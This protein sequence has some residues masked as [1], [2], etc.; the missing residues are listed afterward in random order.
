[1]AWI[2]GLMILLMMG[3]VVAEVVLRKYFNTTL[4]G[5]IE[6]SEILLVF[7]VFGAIA[8]AQQIGGHVKTELVTSRLPPRIGGY[9]RAVGLVIVAALLIWMTQ[10]TLA[11]GLDSMESGESRVGVKE[12]PIW[13]AR[14]AI[15][16]G[17]FFLALETLFTAWDALRVAHGHEPPSDGPPEGGDP[18]TPEGY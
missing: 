17:L 12:V 11:R 16:V 8:H 18:T 5:T 7:I 13:P 2:S 14:L 15:P 1:M 4:K 3:L 10:A 6:Y 9:V